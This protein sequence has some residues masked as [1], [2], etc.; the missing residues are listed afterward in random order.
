MKKVFL[1]IFLVFVALLHAQYPISINVYPTTRTYNIFYPAYFNPEEPEN[2]P[3]I[4]TVNLSFT[5][6]PVE[7]VIHGTMQW[8]DESAYAT[9]T[10]IVQ[11][12]LPSHLTNQDIIITNEESDLFDVVQ[13]FDDFID[14]IEDQ[15]L[16]TGRMPD[17]NYNFEVA[18][19]EP[20]HAG[21]EGYEVSNKEFA[22]LTIRSPISISLITPGNPI[23]LGPAPISDS[24]P[25]FIWF[26]NLIDY[27]IK[28]FEI[29]GEYTTPEEI[30]LLEPYFEDRCSITSYIYPT[31][32]PDLMIGGTYAWQVSADVLTPV[33]GE[34]SYKSIIYSFIISTDQ[35]EEMN[36][37]ILINFLEQLNIEGLE[38]LIA[39]INSGYNLKDIFWQGST[40]SMDELKD[41]LEQI[42]N[43]DLKIGNVS[44]E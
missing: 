13:T 5:G 11:Y 25:N 20:G 32:A 36:N 10:P 38:E 21:E 39:L 26:S 1:F 37:Q 9:L 8:Y 18:C 41:I 2:Q 16:E 34:G 19:Y 15:I 24:Y 35:E 6:E 22:T 23:G 14:A 27:T 12:V 43:G 4:F 42:N 44:V 33:G 40:I 7:Y 28:V 17:G 29:D 30:E 31:E 3:L